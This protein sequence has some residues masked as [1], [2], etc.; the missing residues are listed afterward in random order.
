MLLSSSEVYSGPNRGPT[1]EE[2]DFRREMRHS[3][4]GYVLSKLFSEVLAERYRAQYGTKIYAVRPTNVYGPRDDVGGYR[5]RVIPSMLA[6]IRAGQHIDVWGDGSQIRYFVHVADLVRTTMRLVETGKYDSLNVATTERVSILELAEL[7]T[8]IM[9]SPR[10]IRVDPSKPIGVSGR[11]LDVRRMHELIDFVPH[12][13]Y[14]GLQETARWFRS[15]GGHP[16][17]NE[18]VPYEK[19]PRNR[20]G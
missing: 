11:L 9:G 15:V 19:L 18:R 7:V 13:L 1:A 8:E 16:Y 14:D 6:R 4:N 2:D 20:R 3:E 12:S 17:A 10:R 5:Q